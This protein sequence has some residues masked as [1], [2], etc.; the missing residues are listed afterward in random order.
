MGWAGGSAAHTHFE[1][2]RQTQ[3]AERHLVTAELLADARSDG[4]SSGTSAGARVLVRWRSDQAWFHTATVRVAAGQREGTRAQLWLDANGNTTSP[5]APAG[6]VTAAGIA[7]GTTA[8]LGASAFV[9]GT[10]QGI[11]R[12]FE[13][14]RF[15]QWEPE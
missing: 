4:G 13:R 6:S 1:Q 5:P 8:A 11:R 14:R 15:K 9:G 12:A 3:V 10:H 2:L 7:A